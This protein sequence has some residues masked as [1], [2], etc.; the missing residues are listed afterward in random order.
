M[1]NFELR[2]PFST[3]LEGTATTKDSF[4][5]GTD[6]PVSEASFTTAEPLNNTQS[7]GTKSDI[8][9]GT[10]PATGFGVR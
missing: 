4:I 8:P 2:V 3:E 6:S 10:A 7:H 5:W 1:S 9:G